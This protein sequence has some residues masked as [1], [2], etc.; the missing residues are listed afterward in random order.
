MAGFHVTFVAKEQHRCKFVFLEALAACLALLNTRRELICLRNMAL[1]VR[2]KRLDLKR[3]GEPT[4]EVETRECLD[5]IE[6]YGFHIT[7]ARVRI[8]ESIV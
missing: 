3:D 4:P 1:G 6:K 2:L 7:D 5:D 8:T